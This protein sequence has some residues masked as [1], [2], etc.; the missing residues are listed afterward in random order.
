MDEKH[1]ENLHM[2]RQ[3]YCRGMCKFSLWPDVCNTKYNEMI[4]VQLQISTL[5]NFVKR[6]LDLREE[7]RAM[8]WLAGAIKAVCSLVWPDDGVW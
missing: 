7:W 6:L 5:C 8:F 1:N 4:S 3:H 2:P